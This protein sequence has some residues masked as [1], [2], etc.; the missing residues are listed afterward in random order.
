M[1]RHRIGTTAIAETFRATSTSQ[2]IG[3][4][5][6]AGGAVTQATSITTGVTMN[7]PSG[8]ITTVAA[9]TAAAAEDTFTVTCSACTTDSVVVLSTTYA[10]AGL[11]IVY[12]SR[13]AS[14]SFNVTI[15]NVHAADAVNALLV[16]NFAIIKAVTS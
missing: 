15:S 6:G 11:P 14:G 3:Y 1:P 9:T 5:E 2:P 4:N 12:C 10:G 16:I 7:R 13:V 8:Q